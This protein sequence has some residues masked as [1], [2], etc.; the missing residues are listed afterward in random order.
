MLAS[1]DGQHSLGPAVGLHT[2]EPQHDLLCGLSL[3]RQHRHWVWC[4]A[5]T[6][7]HVKFSTWRDQN[8]AKQAER[9][10]FR[11]MGFVWPPYPLCFLSYLLLPAGKTQSGSNSWQSGEQRRNNE[12]LFT[13]C[14]QGVLSLL[15]LGNFVG[16]VLL[17]LLAVGPAG[18]R[19]VHLNTR[20]QNH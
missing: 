12:G 1:L 7:T 8:S 3:K 18:L 2:L 16:L 17:A 9:T 5:D 19:D 11:K 14:V 10:F 15:V 13:L 6:H 20:R 4:Y